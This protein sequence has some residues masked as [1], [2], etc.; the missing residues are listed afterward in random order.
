VSLFHKEPIRLDKPE[1]VIDGRHNPLALKERLITGCVI[2]L[3]SLFIGRMT[4][5]PGAWVNWR[6]TGIVFIILVFF[7]IWIFRQVSRYSRI[8]LDASRRDRDIASIPVEQA[9]VEVSQILRNSQVFRSQVNPSMELASGL[10]GSLLEFAQNTPHLR[11]TIGD[12]AHGPVWINLGKA[13]PYDPHPTFSNIG[14][15]MNWHVTY[16]PG[17]ERIAMFNQ[18]DEPNAEPEY[19]PTVYHWL[20][21]IARILH[22]S[23]E[24]RLSKNK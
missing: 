17:D 8:P 20:L 16:K 24:Y 9:R 14:E 2:T 10:T 12:P 23:E 18:E 13:T 22:T 15:A 3:V 21:F 11:V 6:V 4:T 19:Y 7:A 5:L 1:P